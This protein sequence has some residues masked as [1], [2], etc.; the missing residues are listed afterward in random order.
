MFTEPQDYNLTPYNVVDAETSNTFAAFIDAEEKKRLI[1]ILGRPLY[2]ALIAGLAEPIPKQKWLNIS[3]GC[4]YTQFGKRFHWD[5][6]VESLIPYIYGEWLRHDTASESGNGVVETENE[7]ATTISP[8][9]LMAEAWNDFAR[10]I[11][12]D[13]ED[14]VYYHERNKNTLYGMLLANKDD[15]ESVATDAGYVNF[16]HYLNE[17]FGYPGLKNM[18]NI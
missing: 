6:L 11:G 13:C 4:D 18:F 12:G 8:V 1:K 16:Y 10:R 2:D 9:R 7:N 14:D 3:V 5:G 15:Y 17:E